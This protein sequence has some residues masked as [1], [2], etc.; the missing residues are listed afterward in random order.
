MPEPYI[1]IIVNGKSRRNL[2]RQYVE[3][4]CEMQDLF[5]RR[6]HSEGARFTAPRRPQ[7][8]ESYRVRDNGRTIT[9]QLHFSGP[10][11]WLCSIQEHRLQLK[12]HTDMRIKRHSLVNPNYFPVGFTSVIAFGFTKILIGYDNFINFH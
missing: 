10:Q 9:V 2:L 7:C 3:A 1:H 5:S 6:Q 12:F 11:V 4:E 8:P